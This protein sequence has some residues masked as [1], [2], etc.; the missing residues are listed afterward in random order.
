VADVH[1]C[2]KIASAYSG[3]REDTI[4]CTQSGHWKTAEPLY[5]AAESPLQLASFARE[6]DCAKAAVIP[7]PHEADCC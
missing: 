4:V 1:H 6:K 5:H 7:V 3:K 2:F